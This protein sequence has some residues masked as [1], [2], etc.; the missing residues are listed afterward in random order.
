MIVIRA[1]NVHMALPI[2]INTLE[3]VG[4]ISDSRNGMVIAA[5]EAVTT[6]YERPMER[7]LFHDWRDANPFFH[8]YE[9]LWMLAGRRD[10]APLVRY[11]SRFTEYSD[12]G[13][14]MNAA[15]GWRWRV[16]NDDQLHEIVKQLRENSGTRRAVLQIWSAGE[17]LFM[18]GKDVACNI[19]ATFQVRREGVL[20]MNVFCRSNDIIWGCY[21][22]NAVHFSMLH[23][24]I[25]ARS[26]YPIGRYTQT[27]VNWHAYLDIW[28]RMAPQCVSANYSDPYADGL[29]APTPLFMATNGAVSDRDADDWDRD[30]RM[31]VNASGTAPSES[32]LKTPF[33]RHV[34]LP[35]VRAHD[36]FKDRA[37]GTVSRFIKAQELLN[38]CAAEDWR[39]A[40]RMWLTKRMN[41]ELHRSMLKEIQ[42]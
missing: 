19:A 2:A 21:G 12:D 33:F 40:C 7:V 6:V 22:A 34:A 5:P 39:I 42:K 28:N 26:G 41:N 4:T 31:F 36:V 29:A 23:E 3:Q 17:D 30:C 25:A 1:R 13:I 35:I 16:T 20:D 37:D 15:Y 32:L 27:S 9:S 14:I 8:F 38:A 24:Y 11:V 18:G 10:I